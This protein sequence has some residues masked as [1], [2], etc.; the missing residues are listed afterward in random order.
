MKFLTLE[1]HRARIA[2]VKSAELG[3]HAYVRKHRIGEYLPAQAVYHLG[4]Y[5]APFSIEPTEYDY[6]MRKGMAE[7]GGFPGEKTPCQ[8]C[9]CSQSRHCGRRRNCPDSRRAVQNL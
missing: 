9:Q 5:P 7:N 4:D 8:R 6:N 1:E 2:N 3:N